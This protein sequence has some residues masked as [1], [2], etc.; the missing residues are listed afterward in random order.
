MSYDIAALCDEDHPFGVGSRA[1]D[2][3]VRSWDFAGFKSFNENLTF[4]QF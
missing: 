2:G 3:S 1:E 4:S